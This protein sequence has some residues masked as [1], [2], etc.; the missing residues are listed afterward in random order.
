MPSPRS[1]SDFFLAAEFL[2][3]LLRLLAREEGSWPTEGQASRK[4]GGMRKGVHQ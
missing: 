4:K 1:L 2:N 3:F